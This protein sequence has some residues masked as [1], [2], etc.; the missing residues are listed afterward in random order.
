MGD[1]FVARNREAAVHTR[2]RTNDNRRHPRTIA[3]P[4]YMARWAVVRHRVRQLGRG[5]YVT[6]AGVAS[7]GLRPRAG[8]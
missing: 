7:V 6:G 1:G 5:Q 4:S 8:E 2:G 3:K